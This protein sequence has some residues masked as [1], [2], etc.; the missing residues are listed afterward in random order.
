MIRHILL[1]KFKDSATPSEVDTVKALFNAIPQKI[2]GVIS[3]EWGV[4]D[5]PEGLNQAFSYSV[6]M[7]FANEESRQRYLPHPEHEALKAI[8][9]PLLADIIVFDYT[10]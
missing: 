2:E 8:F 10:M 9:L 4:N 3:V 5:S 7:T 6:L 1:I